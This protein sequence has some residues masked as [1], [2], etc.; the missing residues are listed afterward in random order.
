MCVAMALVS[1]CISVLFYHLELLSVVSLLLC[2][3]FMT[4]KYRN[5]VL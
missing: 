2:L 4:L 3:H 1:L 5:G